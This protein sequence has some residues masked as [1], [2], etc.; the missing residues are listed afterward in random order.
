MSAGSI[1]V[2]I[3]GIEIKTSDQRI[4]DLKLNQSENIKGEGQREEWMMTPGENK[5]IAG[6]CLKHK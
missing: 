2:P 6:L 1:Q 5:S 4:E 3:G